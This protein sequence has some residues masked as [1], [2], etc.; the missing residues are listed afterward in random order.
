F[1]EKLMRYQRGQRRSLGPCLEQLEGRV[2]LSSFVWQTP[3]QVSFSRNR[4]G[5]PFDMFTS[6]VAA[7]GAS[8][9]GDGQITNIGAG[10]ET[11]AARA[12]ARASASAQSPG[13]MSLTASADVSF[14]RTFQLSGS[15]A[16]W[17]GSLDGLLAGELSTP[18]GMFEFFSPSAQVSGR[19]RIVAGTF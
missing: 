18:H 15:P 19:V 3:W 2:L 6:A 4:P 10:G 1:R 9:T 11:G 14:W 8:A 7:F 5:P 13:P 12:A 16:G 17:D